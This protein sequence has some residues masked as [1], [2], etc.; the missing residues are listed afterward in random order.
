MKNEKKQHRINIGM[1][2]AGF[3]FLATIAI[4]LYSYR[5]LWIN[6]D[7]NAFVAWL[8]IF[9]ISQFLLLLDLGFTHKFIKTHIH[10]DD[11]TIKK[12]LP[13]L[14]G[15]LLL[16]GAV[17]AGMLL[18]LSITLNQLNIDLA[19]P[20]ILLSASVLL[21]IA[22][23]AET[24]A[25]K[26]KQQFN[27]IYSINLVSNL[28]YAGILIFSTL[29][30]PILRLGFATIIR[31]SLQF[32]LQNYLLGMGFSL[33]FGRE[34]KGS[35]NVVGLNAS[36]FCLFMLDSAILLK[37]GLAASTIALVI[38]LRKYYDLL[39]GFWDSI[40]SVATIGFAQ[41]TSRHHNILLRGAIAI[42]YIL[43]YLLSD[44]IISL[45]LHSD[46][47]DSSLSIGIALSGFSLSMYRAE[48]TRMYFQSKLNFSRLLLASLGIKMVFL[49]VIWKD[50]TFVSTAYSLQA[51][52]LIITIYFM[53]NFNGK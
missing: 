30:D 2:F 20:Y 53:V 18:A 42:S 35:I 26:I 47:L 33:K 37:L 31:S 38:V 25:L 32:S 39:R 34:M 4:G 19:L 8:A 3:S 23:Y 27:I 52:L 5:F 48:S 45:W 7:K 15:I 41:S 49:L 13:E 6:S 14:R 10:S 11:H 21:N 9:E 29:E 17:A 40:L 43:A 51:L 28:V 36:Y 50:G 24:V 44:W 46:M 12:A 1:L 22:T 16:V